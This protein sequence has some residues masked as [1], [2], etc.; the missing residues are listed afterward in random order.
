MRR[1]RAVDL[2]LTGGPGVAVPV[3][4]PRATGPWQR[5]HDDLA[6]RG[7]AVVHTT[8]GEWLPAALAQPRLRRLLGRDWTRYRRTPEPTVRYRFLASRLLIKYTAAAALRVPPEALD[9]AYRLGGRPYLR[10]FDQVDVSLTHT[11]DLLAVGLSR[12]GRIGID[13]EPAGRRMRFDLLRAQ[14]CTPAEAAE[15]APLPEG[16]QTAETLRLWTLKEAYT[17]ALGQGMRLGFTEFGFSLRTGRLQAPD[18]SPASRGE[19]SFATHPVQGRYLLSVA[20]HDAGLDPAHD[21]SART[22]LDP[23]FLSLM[24]SRPR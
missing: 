19:W 22:M 10:G 12:L 16:R 15:L 3:H 8:W 17:K 23:G 9:L 4:V 1:E 21:T 7:H 14:M 6:E 11:G 13:A 24:A 18:G 2:D 5:V 20:R